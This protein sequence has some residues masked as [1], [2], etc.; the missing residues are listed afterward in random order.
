[1]LP[2]EHLRVVAR[3]GDALYLKGCA[4]QRYQLDSALNYEV[5]PHAL[6]REHGQDGQKIN[7]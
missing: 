4:G 1:M 6:N 3:Q 2:L 5:W 7:H